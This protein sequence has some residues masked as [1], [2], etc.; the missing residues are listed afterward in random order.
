M[1]KPYRISRGIH[2]LYRED[3]ERA[4]RLVW[5]RVA[6]P[7][8]RRGFLKN[9]GLLAMSG[10]LGASIPFSRWMPCGLIPAALAD[11][12]VPFQ[13]PGKD[14]G[15]VVLNDRPVN[16]ETPP[17]LLDDPVT[18]ASRLFVRNNGLPPEQVDPNSWL[19]S[20]A[21]ESA[22]SPRQYSLAELKKRFNPRSLQL[23]IECGGNG[24]YEFNPPA[25]GLQWTQGA[26]GCALWTGVRLKDIL[27]DVGVG[28]DA[29]YVA[30][31]GA[32]RSLSGGPD[33]VPISRGVPIGKA[34]ED[35]TLI[36]WAMNGKD[37]PLLHGYPLRLVCAGWPGSTSGKWL[38]RLL[39]RN[40]VH[41]GPKMMGYSYRIPCEP[42]APGAK[43]PENEMCIIQ[44][45]PVK[46]IITHPKTGAL[47]QIGQPLPIRGH[48][49]SGRHSV[50]A[51]DTSIDF[52]ATWQPCVLE[53][54]A[55]RL[56]WQHFHTTLTLPGRGYYEV[57]ARATN[58]DG[59]MQPML[60]PGWNPEGYLNNAC[61]RIAVKVT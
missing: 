22:I 47:L 49:W 18:P 12:T 36:A 10:A 34:L 32:D 39:I 57:W 37:L 40:R 55:N 14:P 4:D 5:G 26:V 60:V 35:E 31:Y 59:R 29:V 7:V 50:A 9:S 24:R 33:K 16:A 44:S 23:V 41:D 48:A 53:K 52:G 42:V 61:H 2:E 56:A 11:A 38:Q 43:V 20:I 28:K 46:S 45:M 13:L 54:P 27:D 17:D 19:L 3:P 8:S 51:V 58:S 25:S 1:N 15:L 6:Q 30:Y 21:G